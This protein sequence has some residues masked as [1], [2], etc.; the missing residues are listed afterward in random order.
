MKNPAR[1][2]ARFVTLATVLSLISVGLLVYLLWPASAGPT[3]TELQEQYRSLNAEV[4]SWQKNNP[5][6]VRDDLKHLYV[7]DV[8]ARWSEISQ[9]M[10]KLFQ[11][12]GVS[13]PGISYE[14]ATND[15]NMLPG[16]QEVKINTTVTGDYSKVAG[17]INA[18]EQD[19]LFFII[20]RISLNSQEAGS[21]SLSIT[22]DTFLR[23]A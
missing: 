12:N 20:N 3:T 11:A 1:L 9:H 10:E 5:D 23:Q 17:F 15:K 21:V 16:I 13:A 2:K 18:L 14:I 7:E 22:V 8:P 6:K 4:T 19:K